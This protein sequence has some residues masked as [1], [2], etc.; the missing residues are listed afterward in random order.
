MKIIDVKAIQRALEKADLDSLNA[1]QADLFDKFSFADDV[2]RQYG[3][4]KATSLVRAKFSVS[5]PIARQYLN[6]AQY[7]FGSTS[8][9]ERK[10][11][12]G[13]LAS[14]IY[15]SII[16]VERAIFEE[17]EKD[18][19]KVRELKKTAG[20]REVKALK[21]LYKEFRELLRLDEEDAPPPPPEFEMPKL[22]V[23]PSD[24]GIEPIKN[25]EEL[26]NRFRA[27]LKERD[28]KNLLTDG[29]EEVIPE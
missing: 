7:L 25:P 11:W 9:F 15:E 21:E 8:I 6:E 20:A 2:L 13:T 12:R 19:V 27:Q 4:T 16:A 18:G 23:N 5:E 17:V 1:A 14:S 10:Y 26:I 29:T 3:L 24:I 28:S 22:T